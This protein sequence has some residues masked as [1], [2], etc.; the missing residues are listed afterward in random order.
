MQTCHGVCLYGYVCVFARSKSCVH[1]AQRV[2]QSLGHSAFQV[3]MASQ[4]DISD[5]YVALRDQR[6]GKR[7]RHLIMIKQSAEYIAC[8]SPPPLP[9][10]SDLQYMS[11]RKWEATMAEFRKQLAATRMSETVV[12]PIGMSSGSESAVA[13][14]GN[15]DNL[16]SAD[17]SGSAVADDGN[18][19]NLNNADSCESAVAD[20]RNDE[21]EK[22]ECDKPADDDGCHEY[23]MPAAV[24]ATSLPSYGYQVPLTFFFRPPEDA[25]EQFLL[26]S[27]KR[28]AAKA[29]AVAAFQQKEKIAASSWKPC[30]SKKKWV[31][32]MRVARRLHEYCKVNGIPTDRR[33]PAGVL[34]SFITENIEPETHQHKATPDLVGRWFKRWK[35]HASNVTSFSMSNWLGKGTLKTS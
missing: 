13:A 31:I 18:H 17:S 11:K 34:A 8:C 21:V 3:I 7:L 15:D 23:A 25:K 35:A 33:L 16:N 4:C 1:H 12:L 28:R 27:R 10:P 26:F 5:A 19:H 14:N 30:E 22:D 2:L 6:K 9:D 24:W 20:A 32:K 29:A